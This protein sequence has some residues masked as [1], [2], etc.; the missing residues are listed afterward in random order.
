MNKFA[1]IASLGLAAL[2]VMVS[3]ALAQDGGGAAIE[4][5][6]AFGAG[7]VVIGAALGIGKLAG[8]ALESMARQPE[9]AGG[10]QTAM[11]IAAALIE[12]FTFFALVICMQQNPWG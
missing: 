9:A 1:K 5:S 2:L 4:V 11:I 7:L 10:I 8:S 3:P 6:G 12:G